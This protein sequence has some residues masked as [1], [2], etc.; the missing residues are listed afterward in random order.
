MNMFSI[1]MQLKVL[2]GYAILFLTMFMFPRGANMIFQEIKTMVVL[3]I[4][5]MYGS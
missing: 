2:V 4:E 3:F 5:G 1:G